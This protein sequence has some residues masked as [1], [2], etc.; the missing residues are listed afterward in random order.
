MEIMD[1]VT[2]CFTHNRLRLDLQKPWT[3]VTCPEGW[4]LSMRTLGLTAHLNTRTQ[5]LLHLTI[6]A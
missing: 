3:T 4:P 2:A 6:W 1:A 5:I